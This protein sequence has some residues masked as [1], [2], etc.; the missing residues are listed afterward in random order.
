MRLSVCFIGLLCVGVAFSSY[1]A[2]ET[3]SVYAEQPDTYA[4]PVH[5][6][7]PDTYAEPDPYNEPVTYTEPQQDYKPTEY[8]EPK[9]PIYTE[10]VKTPEYPTPEYRTPE[11]PAPEYP[12]PE[13]PTPE[14]PTPE[15]P[16]IDH[17]TP[18]NPYRQG[19]FL[20]SFRGQGPTYPNAQYPGIP[21]L[22]PGLPYSNLLRGAAPAYAPTYP[23]YVPTQEPYVTT[24]EPYATTPEHYVPTSAPYVPTPEPYIANPEPYRGTPE[25]YRGTPEP[26]RATPETYDLVP[27]QYEPVTLPHYYNRVYAIGN[28]EAGV[29]AGG[30]GAA[31]G[32]LAASANFPGSLQAFS[33]G[34]HGIGNANALAS[35]L[36][37]LLATG[38]GRAPVPGLDQ[39][40]LN[41]NYV[42]AVRPLY[43]PGFP[44][45][46]PENTAGNARSGAG[47]MAAPVHGPPIYQ[48]RQNHYTPNHRPFYY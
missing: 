9:L 10:P 26:Y 17:P 45:F 6:N 32:A 46:F 1:D 11:Y 43:L 34:P 28:A 3:N 5:Y 12:T 2:P 40:V 21:E 38:A 44:Y 35:T 18:Y 39:A 19:P 48:Y 16:T 25:P 24:P 37:A 14:Y 8:T 13:Y 47:R 42:P 15:Y 36:G 22:Y 27:A 33:S 30:L 20:S 31:I 29:R 41:P 7:Q 4:E 23:S